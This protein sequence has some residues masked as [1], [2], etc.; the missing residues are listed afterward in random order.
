MKRTALKHL[1]AWKEKENRKPMLI[2]GARQ[3][4]KTWR[5]NE[6]IVPLF[7]SFLLIPTFYIFSSLHFTNSIACFSSLLANI[8][9]L[10]RQGLTDICAPLTQTTACV[11]LANRTCDF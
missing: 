4:G 7:P 2:H 1:V 3:V 8:K 11:A 10:Q 6:F 9:Q 5:I